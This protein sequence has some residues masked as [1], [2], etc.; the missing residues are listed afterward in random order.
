MPKP[1]PTRLLLWRV[2]KTFRQERVSKL[3]ASWDNISWSP[4]FFG[5]DASGIARRNILNGLPYPDASLTAVYARRILEHCTHR[6]AAVLL[7]EIRRCLVPG[8][9]FRAS[10][11]PFE[12]ACRRYLTRLDQR[13][14]D[15]DNP[16][17]ARLHHISVIEIVDQAARR[18]AGGLLAQNVRAGTVSPAEVRAQFGNALD[19]MLGDT[20]RAPGG[21]LRSLRNLIPL[22]LSA[23]RSRDPRWTREAYL[24]YPDRAT[25]ETWLGKAG[26]VNICFPSHESSGIEGETPWWLDTGFDNIGEFEPS[27]YVE[28]SRRTEPVQEA[29]R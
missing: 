26:F 13:R 27:L 17:L 10:V 12:A 11:P 16:E 2:G 4:P 25:L 22:I 19:F 8:G 14:A 28:A 9:W 6:E 18:R 7:A 21:L 23:G 1:R 15:P 5:R 20:A 3:S 29:S 24:S